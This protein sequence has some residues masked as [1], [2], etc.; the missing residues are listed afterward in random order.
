MKRMKRIINNIF[1]VVSLLAILSFNLLSSMDKIKIFIPNTKAIN[2]EKYDKIV[3]QKY[4]FKMLNNKKIKIDYKNVFRMFFL[5]EFQ[6]IVN[7]DVEFINMNILGTMKNKLNNNNDVKLLDKINQQY[8]NSLLV[9]IDMDLKIDERHILSEETDKYG[10]K[11]KKFVKTTIWQLQTKI[12]LFDIKSQK[13][14][15]KFNILKKIKEEKETSQE[16]NFK[17]LFDMTMN[18]FVKKIKRKGHKESRFLLTLN[19]KKDYQLRRTIK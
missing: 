11:K 16:F 3:F 15:K 2:M 5:T 12:K 10:D 1:I 7:K 14:I 8:I 9:A 19:D 4:Q 18:D 17:L 13:I 6:K